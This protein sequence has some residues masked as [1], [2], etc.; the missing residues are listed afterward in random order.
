MGKDNVYFHTIY[1]PSV[2]IG[3]GRN[4]T[5]LHH[6]STTGELVSLDNNA[7]FTE[8][9]VLFRI[10]NVRGRKVFQEQ[11]SRSLWAGC[12]RHRDTSVGLEVLFALDKT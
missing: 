8:N 7:L 12:E 3:D 5:K 10:S 1:F 6:I 4:W 11:K 9:I 2:Q